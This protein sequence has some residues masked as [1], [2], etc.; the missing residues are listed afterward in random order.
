MLKPAEQ[1]FVNPAAQL[2]PRTI[3]SCSLSGAWRLGLDG[4]CL[5]GLCCVERV[6]FLPTA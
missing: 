3:S 2:S 4:E 1:F 5:P 6:T